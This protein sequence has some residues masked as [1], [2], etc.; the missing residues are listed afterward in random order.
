MDHLDRLGSPYSKDFAIDLILN[1]LLMSY[2]TFITN[3]NMNG[4]DNHIS[5]LHSMLKKL[6]KISQGKPHKCLWIT[7]GKSRIKKE[8]RNWR[9]SH[10]LAREKGRKLPNP[11]RQRRRRK[12][13]TM[14]LALSVDLLVIG[15]GIVL[16]IL[17]G[18][19]PRRPWKAL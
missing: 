8:R 14:V 15:K 10:A 4:R 9:E 2:D 12:W 3:Y 18:W 11:N 19:K 13:L 16:L 7:K 5:M 1:S 6:R 17:Q